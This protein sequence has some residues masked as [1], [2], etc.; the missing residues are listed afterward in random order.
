MRPIP[1]TPALLL[2][3]ALFVLGACQVA[4]VAAPGAGT[5]PADAYQGLVGA[6]LA[7]VTLPADL[8]SRIV[9]PGIAVTMDYRSDRMNIEI[10]GAGRI[11]RVYCG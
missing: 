2:L 3:P 11:T 10:D 8:D 7:A 6:P 1:R 9:G 4:P 5:C